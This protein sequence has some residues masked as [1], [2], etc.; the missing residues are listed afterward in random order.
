MRFLEMLE[1]PL[2]GPQGE[3]W[4]NTV[5]PYTEDFDAYLDAEWFSIKASKDNARWREHVNPLT[6]TKDPNVLQSLWKDINL[7]SCSCVYV[8]NS[9]S[10]S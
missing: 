8:R 6:K 7:V 4:R 5:P 10:T 3:V 9:S 1:N 2:A